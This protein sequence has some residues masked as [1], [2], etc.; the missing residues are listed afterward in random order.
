[1]LFL[2]EGVHTLVDMTFLFDGYETTGGVF[3]QGH[4]GE[5]F[6]KSS[7]GPCKTA[8]GVIGRPFAGSL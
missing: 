8:F 1:M 5:G 7:R 6:A 3:K 2:A 4:S